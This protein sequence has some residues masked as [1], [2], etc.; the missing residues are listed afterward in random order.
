MSCLIPRTFLL[1]LLGLGAV[2]AQPVTPATEL[3]GLFVQG[4]LPFAGSPANL[5]DWARGVPLPVLPEPARTAFLNGAPGVVFDASTGEGKFVLVSADDGLCSCV[6]DMAHDRA[7][8]TALEDVLAR[9]GLAF[10]MVIERDDRHAT[11]L[12]YREYFASRDGRTW[13]ILAATVKDPGGGQAMLTA[14]P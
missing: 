11:D 12:H 7:V 8:R 3:A 4:C 10:R 13:R 9:A 1:V 5:R 2:R 14:G 6:T